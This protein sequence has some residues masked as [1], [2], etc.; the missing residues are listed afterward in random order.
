[1]PER[2]RGFV[3]EAGISLAY[4]TKIGWALIP[5]MV[6]ALLLCHGA[7]GPVHQLLTGPSPIAG[8]MAP[9]E[10]PTEETGTV[11]VDSEDLSY[12]AAG[13]LLIAGALFFWFCSNRFYKADA[14][15]HARVAALRCRC[16]ITGR[17]RGPT[18]FLLRVLRL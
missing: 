2:N 11:G 10:L 14:A 5:L 7:F 18:V 3:T 15:R 16:V 9:T 4:R 17:R 13:L 6:V 1:M 8:H 12:Y